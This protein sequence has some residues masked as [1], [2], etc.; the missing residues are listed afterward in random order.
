MNAAVEG[1]DKVVRGRASYNGLTIYYMV[2]S[3]FAVRQ[4]DTG[5]KP[6]SVSQKGGDRG[7]FSTTSVSD[8]KRSKKDVNTKDYRELWNIVGEKNFPPSD[9][10][11]VNIFSFC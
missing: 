8:E 6:K 3:E 11:A 7:A 1:G 10:G 5:E 4:S 2:Y 9:E